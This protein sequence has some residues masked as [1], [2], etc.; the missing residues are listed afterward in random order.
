M[1]SEMCIRDSLSQNGRLIFIGLMGG[2]RADINL[3]ALLGKRLK[4]IGSTLRSRSISEKAQV[5]DALSNWVWPHLEDGR[6]KPIIEAVIP[7]EEAQDAHDLV[8]SN[9]TFGKVVLSVGV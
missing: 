1:G 3:A 4:L 8:E 9:D 6:I 5:M 7:I 2:A